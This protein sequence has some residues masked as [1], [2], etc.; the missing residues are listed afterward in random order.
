MPCHANASTDTR[1]RVRVRG[2]CKIVGYRQG[3]GGGIEDRGGIAGTWL[4]II[5]YTTFMATDPS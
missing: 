5:Q 4:S 1:A 2:S 3:I